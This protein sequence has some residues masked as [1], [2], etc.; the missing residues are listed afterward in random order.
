M[1]ELRHVVLF[2]FKDGVNAAECVEE[3][4]R[5]ADTMDE[6]NAF[7]WGNNVS[8]EGLDGGFTHCFQLWFAGTAERDHYLNHPRHKAFVEWILPRLEKALVVDYVPG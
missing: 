1:A 3:F 4:Q 5:F 2:A 8:P 6:V 7:E